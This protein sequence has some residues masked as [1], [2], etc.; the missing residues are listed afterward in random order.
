MGFSEKWQSIWK[1]TVTILFKGI[2]WEEVPHATR[3]FSQIPLQGPPRLGPGSGWIC[4]TVIS[5]CGTTNASWMRGRVGGMEFWWRKFPPCF[6]FGH[7]QE[8]LLKSCLKGDGNMCRYMILNSF[9]IIYHNISCIF[10][11]IYMRYICCIVRF[12]V[13]QHVFDRQFSTS[14]LDIL[15]IPS[16]RQKLQ[17]RQRKLESP[18]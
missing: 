11:Y 12:S 2:I 14:L 8:K 5:E 3:I 6:V 9:Y 18:V 4:L 1:V 16:G 7:L 17:R 10:I 13:T 15:W